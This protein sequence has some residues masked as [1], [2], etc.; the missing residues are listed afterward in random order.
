MIITQEIIDA[1]R[2]AYPVFT[3]PKWSDTTVEQ[4]LCEGD[5]ETG[6]RG[7]GTY[8]D[9]CHNFKRRGMFLYTAHWLA[10]TY[11]NGDIDAGGNMSGGAKWA[12]SGKSVGDESA[13]FNNGS[14]ANMAVGDSWL[15][16]TAFGQQWLRLRR[17][18]GMG[19]LAV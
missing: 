2:L 8:Q 3:D 1:F 4:A 18:A 6:G 10:S 7:W 11:P 16:T 5:A 14:L 13:S 15:A 12:T 9:D 17:R 19:A